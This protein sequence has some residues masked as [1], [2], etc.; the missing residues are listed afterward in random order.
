M[1]DFIPYWVFFIV[2]NAIIWI[3]IIHDD[4]VVVQDSVGTKYTDPYY[5]NQGNLTF[6][7]DLVY[8]GGHLVR[9]QI[10]KGK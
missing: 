9:C 3:F 2:I 1:R 7:R 5:C 10:I 8:D 4:N 6:R